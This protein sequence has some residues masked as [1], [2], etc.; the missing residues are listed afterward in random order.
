MR[1]ILS[2]TGLLACLLLAQGQPS[3]TARFHE[4]YA[5]PQPAWVGYTV[6]AVPGHEQNCNYNEGVRAPGPVQLEPPDRVQ[7]LFRI[8][9]GKVGKIRAISGD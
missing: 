1:L 9:D 8:Q 2:G 7:I 5:Q 3:L 4:Q 6:P